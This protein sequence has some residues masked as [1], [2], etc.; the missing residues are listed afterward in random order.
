MKMS[1]MMC[2]LVTC[3]SMAAHASRLV[4]KVF[5]KMLPGTLT[6]ACLLLGALTGARLLPETLTGACLLL[7]TLTGARLLHL[8][9][10]CH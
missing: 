8:I 10:R 7:G 5:M 6:G 4:Y 3:W 1:C 9:R 2:L